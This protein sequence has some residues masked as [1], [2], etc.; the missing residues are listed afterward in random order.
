MTERLYYRDPTLLE[1]EGTI[2]DTGQRDKVWYTVLDRSAFYPTSGGQLHDVGTLGGNRVIDVKEDGDDD[3]AVVEHITTERVG[4]PGD[5]V[6]GVVDADRRLDNQQKHTAQHIISQVFADS[7][8]LETVSVHLGIDYGAVELDTDSVEESL[9]EQVESRANEIIQACYPVH[10]L[11]LSPEEAQ[12]LPLRKRPPERERLRVIRIG[13][14]DYSACGGTHCTNT[15]QV[16]LIKLIG[17]ETMR[18]HALVKFLAGRQ[19]L[20]DYTRRWQLTATLA[21]TLTCHFEDL[22]ERVSSLQQDA[23]DCRRQLRQAQ[24]ELLPVKAERLASESQDMSGI[25]VAIARDND[26]D[27]KVATQL[28]RHAADFNKGVAIIL[29]GGRMLIAAAKESPKTAGQLARTLCDL[30]GGR[31]GGNDTQAQVGQ[32]DIDNEQV[33]GHLVAKAI[34][35]A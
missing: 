15:G 22:P 9:L 32:V 30:T 24:K 8:G 27:P 34:D 35:E 12:E 25:P 28:A 5:T 33:L 11:F 10:V 26:L 13:D 23:D 14:L 3:Q 2:T 31:G 4:E 21:T 16:G 20:D 6:A 1:F 19:A 7:S 29:T 17:V 18:G